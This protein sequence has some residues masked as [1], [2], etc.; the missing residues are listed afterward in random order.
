MKTHL[1]EAGEQLFGLLTQRT[2][3]VVDTEYTAANDE[4]G[5]NKLISIAIVPVELGRKPAANKEFYRVMNPGVPIS[6]ASTR[7]HGFTDASVKGKRDFA[8]YAPQILA[9][10]NDPQ[11]VF[12]CHTTVDA[13]VLLD[14]LARLDDRAAEGD[15]AATVGV[16]DMP[17]LPIL[18]TSTLPKLVKYPGIGHRG[19]VSLA[20]LCE[21]TSAEFKG[22]AHNAR[23]DARATASAL[24]ELLAYTSQHA[25]YWDLESLLADHRAGTTR[26][27]KGPAYIRSKRAVDPDLPPEHIAKHID[28]LVTVGSKQQIADWV[29]L[30][31]EC[32]E[33]RCQWLRDEAR[34]AA[35]LNAAALVDP[36]MALLPHLTEPGQA[37]TLLGAV[38]EV[39]DPSQPV[40]G[41]PG[42][43]NTRAIRWWGKYRSI[44]R[45]SPACGD[46]SSQ[47]CPSCRH[48]KPC[49]R[50]VLHHPVAMVASKMKDGTFDRTNVGYLFNPAK[51]PSLA[52]WNANHPDVA[53]HAAWLIIDCE[54]RERRNTAASLHTSEAIEMDLHLTEPRLTVVAASI[55]AGTH[56]LDAAIALA[57]K[58]LANRT[59]DDGYDE[60]KQ[61]VTWSSQAATARQQ[62]AAKPATT[63]PRLARP[64]GR[65]NQNPYVV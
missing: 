61:W 30:A 39:I 20:T 16:A 47:M 29:A 48:G 14:G 19:V 4:R 24:L 8:F 26:E 60:L 35:D 21:L 55:V 2:L 45:S 56:G 15:T 51:S 57:D 44:V 65:E 12:V 49:A 31:R 63:H 18:D 6:S 50:D 38:Y 9:A 62:K 27:P 23:A 17:D 10:L 64:S 52:K 42:M 53:A 5:G 25:T 33:L 46:S 22:K 37:G 7:V 11:G 34:V 43:A 41:K 1:S 3:Y 58:V 13:R 59:T 36:L 32:S 28:P 54:Q 40:S